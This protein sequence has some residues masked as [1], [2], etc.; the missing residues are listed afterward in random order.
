MDHVGSG[1]TFFEG[2]I[3]EE[4]K[5]L[6][7]RKPPRSIAVNFF[8]DVPDAQVAAHIQKKTMNKVRYTG[9]GPMKIWVKTTK[10][11]PD[12]TKTYTV[13]ADISLGMGASNSVICVMCNETKEIIAE[14]ANATTPPYALARIACAIC[15]WAGGRSR[16]LLIWE[17]NGH[18][19]HDF[20]NQIVST[21]QYPNVFFHRQD[22]T[23]AKKVG[24]RWG[25]RS[26]PESKAIALG[27]L[28]RAY[29]HGG[30]INPSEMQ[31]A[32]SI[33]MAIWV[34]VGGRGTLAGA[35]VGTWVVNGAKSWFTVAAPDYW[36]YF[37]GALFIGVTVLLPRGVLGTLISRRAD[38]KPED[39]S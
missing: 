12:Q 34:A 31:P 2:N 22:G 23:T 14:W 38:E 10:G 4:H 3:L 11:R 1:D 35:L 21:Y 33:E 37:L 17:N 26:N 36:L 30:I 15:L 16:P 7:A 39:D 32:N 29:A 19:G 5:M 20:G 28:R 18:P 27:E 8:K 13:A 25:W 9:T 6:F 24:K